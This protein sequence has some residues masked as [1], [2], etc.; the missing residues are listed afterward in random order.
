VLLGLDYKIVYKQG[1]DNGVADALSR[2]V[3]TDFVFAI[4]SATPQWL[5]AV[6]ESYASNT[7]A[8]DLI[9]KLSLQGDSVPNFPLHNQCG[10][11]LITIC[12]CR[13]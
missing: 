7:Q 11:G 8:R 2:R 10:L 1:S 12:V 5:E 6:V 4:S 9:T 3:S 13:S